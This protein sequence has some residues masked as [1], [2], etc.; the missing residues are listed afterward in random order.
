MTPSRYWVRLGEHSLSQLDWTEQLRRSAFS[1]THPSY[2]GSLQSY[3][4]DLRLLRLGTPV[5]L[6]GSVQPLPLATTCAA[7]GTECHISGWGITNRPWSKGALGSGLRMGRS[8]G[9]RVRSQGSWHLRGRM[10]KGSNIRI[11]VWGSEIMVNQ[12]SWESLKVKGQ[13]CE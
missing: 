9:C 8:L 1:V 3:D 11:M 2:Q 12:G 4:H 10:V 6:T 5:L 13:G 7:A